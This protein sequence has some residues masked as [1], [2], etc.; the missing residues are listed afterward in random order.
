[1][2]MF[3]SLG[4]L[5]GLDSPTG[6]GFVEG[7]AGTTAKLVKE[8]MDR[9]DDLVQ[10]TAEYSIKRSSAEADRVQKELRENREK[11]MSIAGKAGGITGAEYLIRTYGLE[12]A[13]NKAGQIETLKGFGVN[14]EFATKDENQTT[15]DE[16]TKFTVSAPAVI[17]TGEIKD[18]GLLS[19]I[20]LGRDIGAEVQAK[21]DQ[22]AEMLGTGAFEKTDL[23]EMPT[24]KGFDPSDLGMM[25]DMKDEANRRLRLAISAQENEDEEGYK[26]HMA[27]ATKM[28][29]ML[30][31]LDVK[32][33]TESGGRAFKN[34]ISSHIEEASG[35][36]GNLVSDGTGGF[37]FKATFEEAADASKVGNASAALTEVYSNA[38]RSGVPAATALKSIYEAASQNRLPALAQSDTGTFSIIVTP[39]VL[40]EGG[41]TGGKG[42]FA[43]S[44]K[45]PPA[46][47]QGGSSSATQ[48]PPASAPANINQL[49]AR[50]NTAKSS[51]QKSMFLRRIYKEYGGSQN[52]PA[53]IMSQLK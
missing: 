15:I 22:A 32:E 17:T 27:A 48:Q 20:G 25:S 35:L 3:G 21:V 36:K 50:H 52:V 7:F 18:T 4:K 9:T 51:T 24:A 14:P 42:V 46:I 2:A 16:L 40:I 13:I 41:F 19:K 1:M 38:I 11:V 45:A 28:R 31:T 8:D 47:N 43:P 5:L 49:I 30:R 29:N 34:D 26:R 6:R 44:I 39:N 23:G 33:L 53:N 37:R 12:E 10:K